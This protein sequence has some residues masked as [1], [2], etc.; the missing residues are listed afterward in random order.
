M[1]SKLARFVRKS[2]LQ[3][4]Y[5]SLMAVVMA[6]NGNN[7]LLQDSVERT[8]L[9]R[10]A[11]SW[12]N[13]D[14]NP[15]KMELSAADEKRFSLSNLEK[16]WT[17]KLAPIGRTPATE[18]LQKNLVRRRVNLREGV[19]GAYWAISPTGENCR[20]LPAMLVGMLLTNPLRGKLSEGPCQRDRCKKWFIKRRP[21]QKCCGRRCLAIVTTTERVNKQRKDERKERLKKVRAAHREWRILSRPRPNWKTWV[22]K[23]TGLST[24]FLARNFAEDG[25]AKKSATDAGSK[26]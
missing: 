19:G 21:G 20:D 13:S 4:D 6:L 1:N 16:V 5:S 25:S 26:V 9:V 17:W 22:A 15:W 8:A 10:Y 24:R 18:E 23:R 7:P 12:N 11:D 14:R 2:R 3:S